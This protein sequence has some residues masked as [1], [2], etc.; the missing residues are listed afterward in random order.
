MP[1]RGWNLGGI[2]RHKFQVENHCV[3]ETI[4]Q[5]Y[6]QES[7]ANLGYMVHIRLHSETLFQKQ[8]KN[9]SIQN[10][11]VYKFYEVQCC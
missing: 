11:V 3:L 5:L 10:C 8:I 6:C 9:L 4:K 1:L 7:E 2:K